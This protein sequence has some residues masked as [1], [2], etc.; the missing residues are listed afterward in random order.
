MEKM[1]IT[2]FLMWLG[3]SGGYCGSS[4][5]VSIAWKLGKMDKLTFIN[6][7]FFFYFAIDALMGFLET[8]YLSKIRRQ[9]LKHNH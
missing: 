4:I 2:E 7:M 6:K 3:E 9:R 5:A 8:Y 1:V